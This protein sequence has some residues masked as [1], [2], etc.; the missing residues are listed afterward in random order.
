VTLLLASPCLQPGLQSNLIP[1]GSIR[2]EHLQQPVGFPQQ[3][4]KS[5][6]VRVPV[7]IAEDLLQALF[8]RL[9]GGRGRFPFSAAYGG[10]LGTR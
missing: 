10:D 5:R 8:D 6:I 3:P 4:G 1:Q 9:Y 7:D 2:V